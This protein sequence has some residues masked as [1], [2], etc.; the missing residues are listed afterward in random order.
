MILLESACRSCILVNN[1]GQC[2]PGASDDLW[3]SGKTY[4]PPL[5]NCYEAGRNLLEN[6]QTPDLSVDSYQAPNNLLLSTSYK[7]LHASTILLGIL[8]SVTATASPGVPPQQAR[9]S[10]QKLA[11][12]S[13]VRHLRDGS[14]VWGVPF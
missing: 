10:M 2:Y 4:C 3:R 13:Q 11:L 7:F 5:A 8:C 6:C 12:L 9:V 14:L 1:L